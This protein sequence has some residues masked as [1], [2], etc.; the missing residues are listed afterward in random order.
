MSMPDTM[1][2]KIEQL[3]SLLAAMEGVVIGYS[4][5][6]DSTLLAAAAREVLGERAVCVL[7]SSATYP[8]SEVKEALETAD[9]LGIP[10]TRID[11][12]ELQ[13]ENF[14]ANPP[15]H[16]YYCKQELFGRLAAIA[17]LQGIRWIADGSNHDDLQDYRPGAR[18]AAEFGVRS[19]LREA[20]LN[21][22]E[23]REL[24]RR[25]GLPTWD[26]PA[27]ACLASRI[28]YGTRIDPAVLRR[29]EE[30]EQ[31][32]KGLGFR[33]VRVRHHGTVARIEVEPEEID[34][35][36]S[37]DLRQS[38]AQK[39]RELQYLYTA[40]DLDGYRTGSMNAVLDRNKKV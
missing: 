33:Q 8:A 18:A 2:E 28:P 6:C 17:K 3:R 29:L 25:L 13:N 37:A 34:R 19:P 10:V 5:G 36:A 32:L 30:A 1:N 15:D 35:L 11:T 40:V 12:E 21:K 4:G 14:L 23:I 27:F 24:S 39:F 26:K 31:F 9:Q 22:A 38:V 20:G 7:A 16:C